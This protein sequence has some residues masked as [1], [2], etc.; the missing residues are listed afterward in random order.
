ML[1]TNKSY[2][3]SLHEVLQ[4]VVPQSVIDKGNR[5]KSWKYGYNAE[6]D[7]VCISKDGTLGNIIIIYGLKIGLP[8]Q[9]KYFRFQEIN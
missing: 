7:F 8:K 2:R 3:R 1:K 9:P 4:D 6:Y 5:N